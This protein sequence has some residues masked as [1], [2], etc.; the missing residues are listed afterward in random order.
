L[1][2][3]LLASWERQREDRR[4]APDQTTEDVSEADLYAGNPEDY[5]MALKKAPPG[6]RL[7]TALRYTERRAECH[8]ARSGRGIEKGSVPASANPAPCA[9]PQAVRIPEPA[10]GII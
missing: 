7:L 6:R 1:F 3:R 5:A 4:T 2:T 8:A 9:S 10:Q